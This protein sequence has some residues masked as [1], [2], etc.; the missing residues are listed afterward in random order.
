MWELCRTIG[1]IPSKTRPNQM[2]DL[3]QKNRL[4]GKK[5]WDNWNLS[6]DGV[7][8][9]SKELVVIFRPITIISLCLKVP[10]LFRA[11]KSSMQK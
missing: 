5:K 6:M 3:I 2:V 7:L 4:L 1:P 11:A 9:A 10:V 8:D